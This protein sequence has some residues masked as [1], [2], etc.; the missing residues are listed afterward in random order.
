MKRIPLVSKCFLVILGLLFC[1]AGVFAEFPKTINVQGKVTNDSGG[2]IT[3]TTATIRLYISDNGSTFTEFN[4]IE[5]NPVTLDSEGL[6]NV[7]MNLDG[8]N[9]DV[10]KNYTFKVG[11]L[12]DGTT[13]ESGVKP[14]AS[15]PFAFYASSSTY[16]S[17][18]TYSLV[19]DPVNGQ[20]LVNGNFTTV[21][22]SPTFNYNIRVATSI[23]A[24]SA[25]SITG[26]GSRGQVWGMD[27]AN[28]QGWINPGDLAISTA[29]ADK[30][31]GIML[32]NSTDNTTGLYIPANSAVLKLKA[33]TASTIGGVIVS[34]GA[35]TGLTI[36]TDGTLGIS[37]ATTSSYGVVKV[38]TGNGLSIGTNNGI[39]SMALANGNTTAGAVKVKT[40]SGLT[41]N[42]GTISISTDTAPKKDSNNLLTSGVIYSTITTIYNNLA[43]QISGVTLSAGSNVTIDNDNKINVA[44]GTS[45][46]LGVVKVS[47]GNG[48][49]IGTN[50]G[51]ISM[52]LANGNTTAGAVK[53]KTGSGLTYNSGTISISTDT[54]PKKDSNNLL[55]SGVIYS[56]IT[57]IYNNLAGQISGVTLSAGSNVTIDN[58]NK[59]N[60]ATGTSSGLG[61]VKV[62]TGNGLSIGTNDGT[63]SMAL[64]NTNNNAG[65]VKVTTGNG[66]SYDTGT[67]TISISTDTEP[68]QYSNNLLTSGVIYSTLTTIYDNLAS[69]ISGITLEGGDGINVISNT[70]SV[71]MAENG[72]LKFVNKALAVS[73]DNKTIEISENDDV[74]NSTWTL[75]VKA[76]PRYM[77]SSNPD[78]KVWGYRSS[79]FG[80]QGW[81]SI[82]DISGTSVEEGLY[83]KNDVLK[84]STATGTGLIFSD[85]TTEAVLKISTGIGLVINDSNEIVVST[86]AGLAFDSNNGIVV[87][88]GAGL[89]FDDNKV[90]V[91]TGVGLAFDSNNGIV[92]ST[93][94]G[95]AFDDNKVIVSTGAGLAIDDNNRVYVATATVG[96]I[97]GFKLAN[98]DAH[99]SGLAMGDDA[100]LKVNVGTGGLQIDDANVIKVMQIDSTGTVT[101]SD[102]TRED[103]LIWAKKGNSQGWYSISKFNYSE[104]SSYDRL[105]GADLAEIYQSTEKL[106]PGDVVSIDPAKDNAIVKTKVA[107]DTMVAGVISTEPGVLMNQDEKGYKLA[108][109]GKVP[110][111]VCNE[112]GAIKRGDLLVSASIPGYAK[113]AGD[114]PKVGTVIGK[115]L[116]NSDSQKG[117]IL[118][119]V[120]LQ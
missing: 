25:S 95:L 104:Y 57:T 77:D 78:K 111:K 94:A 67:G 72:G 14:F 34:T 46:G 119:L 89:A 118:V 22:S 81:L 15:N 71:D 105:F 101:L 27:T 52:A 50:D 61:V 10:N 32:G 73:V 75:K 63:I 41:Y 99:N 6:Y 19:L 88:T 68:R 5:G 24:V 92:V 49:S 93:G 48:L 1:S 85:S 35:G 82:T 40:G 36:G 45:S 21:T 3:G 12:A 16:S 97:G 103:I 47:T 58:D 30:L 66:L 53:V 74:N 117:T 2:P 44:T 28:T 116:E 114:N 17:T 96:N 70:I 102:N 110:T 79:D 59:I 37:P 69:Q 23:Y 120:N 38:S 112:G 56:T 43:G 20:K 83:Y 91:S 42:S 60:V 80:S 31:G 65:T 51:T 108:L 18:S 87:S 54:A 90:I 84:V 106:V 64:A 62:S 86:G 107:E 39:I 9:F 98:A 100:I 26:K 33:A 113:K 109:V 55:T 76:L 11:V 13:I 115:A 8:M 4:P 7:N 29:A